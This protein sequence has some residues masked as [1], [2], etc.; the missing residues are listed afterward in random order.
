M[1]ICRKGDRG[2]SVKA[3]Q[4]LLRLMPD[5][6]FGQLTEDAVKEFQQQEHLT[7]DGV[8]GLKTW[9]HLL[10]YVL[11][12]SNRVITE[13]I[14]HCTATPE[15]RDYTVDDIRRWH[16]ERGYHDIGYHYVVYRDGSVHKGRSVNISGAHCTAHNTHSIGVVYVG[17]LTSDGKRSKD[18]RTSAQRDSLLDLMIYL[19]S[20]YPYARIYGHRDFA[21]KDCPFFDAKKEYVFH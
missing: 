21:N 6:V 15:G 13:I 10:G 18:T 9:S 3:L 19:Q 4:R 2:I 14:V 17:G 8:V 12:P 5:G 7:A 1:I 20:L 16:R 11:L